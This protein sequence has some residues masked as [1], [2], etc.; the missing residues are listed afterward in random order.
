MDWVVSFTSQPLYPREI[1]PVPKAWKA[2]LD[3]AGEEKNK[4]PLPEFEARTVQTYCAIPAVISY[5]SQRR[6]GFTA[7]AV[8]WDVLQASL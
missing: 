7:S 1:T 6:P 2:G 5:L 8:L 4:L 3:V